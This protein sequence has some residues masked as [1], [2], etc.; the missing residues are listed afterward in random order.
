MIDHAM[1]TGKFYAM[2]EWAGGSVADFYEVYYAPQQ[3]GGQW[4]PLY[5][6]AYYKSTVTRLYNFDGEA[7]VPTESTVISYSEEESPDGINYKVVTDVQSFATYEGAEAYI[8]SQ[9]S[10]NY[11]IVSP[12]PF[13]SP[14]PL[15]ALNS[16][17]RIHSSGDATSQT[18]VKIFEYLGSDES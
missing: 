5:Y 8:A 16:Y 17:E 1:V 7:V 15:E 13:A 18:T 12:N 4:V 6:P 11:R 9:A 10:P 2:V 14:V 3:T